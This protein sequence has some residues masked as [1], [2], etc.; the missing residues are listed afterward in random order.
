MTKLDTGKAG[1]SAQES[2]PPG[3]LTEA[4]EAAHRLLIQDYGTYGPEEP[5]TRIIK[6]VEA[7][8]TAARAVAPSGVPD[9]FVLVRKEPTKEAEREGYDAAM[10]CIHDDIDRIVVDSIIGRKV[11]AHML[12]LLSAAPTAQGQSKALAATVAGFAPPLR[13]V[14]MD[15]PGQPLALA[16]HDQAG[17]RVAVAVKPMDALALAVDLTSSARRRLAGGAS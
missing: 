5:E 15:V 8:L 17:E 14:L 16:V 7:A 10:E 1:S 4:L 6:K 9:G 13:L 3:N 11:W 12:R 2:A